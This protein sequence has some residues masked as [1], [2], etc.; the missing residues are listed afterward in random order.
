MAG[1]RF[2]PPRLGI[3][4]DSLR[5]LSLEE[6]L[7]IYRCFFRNARPECDFK[8]FSNSAA[9]CRSDTAMYVLSFHGLHLDV[10]GIPPALCRFI[11]SRRSFV[12]SRVEAFRTTSLCKM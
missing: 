2:A 11:R 4:R 7:Q 9:R 6:R 3:R 5:L 1:L 10:C 8:Y 12:A